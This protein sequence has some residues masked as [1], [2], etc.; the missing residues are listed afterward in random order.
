MGK[1]RDWGVPASEKRGGICMEIKEFAVKVERAVRKK[2]GADYETECRE[3]AKN[4]GVLLHGLVIRRAE[5]AIAPTIYLNS[6]WEA[7]E[8]GMT[9]SEVVSRILT[10]YEEDVVKQGIDV[11]FFRD[12]EK[13]KER[14]CFRLVNRE[15][16]R[17]QLAE[18]PYLPILDLAV[19]FYYAFD[20]N[21][22]SNGSI[23]VNRSHMELWKTTERELFALAVKNMPK[24][25]PMEMGIL[26]SMLLDLIKGDPIYILTNVRH[27][28]GACT[29]LYPGA[30]E[31]MGEQ[32][33]D[34]Y[35]LIPCSVHEFLLLPV[36]DERSTEELKAMIHE[37]NSCELAP[38]DVLSDALYYYDVGERRMS[39][40][41]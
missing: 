20:G 40:V 8:E 12:F 39:I 27:N 41:E 13:V 19:C 11:A 21:G 30:L 26:G 9:L 17:E 18:I 7:Y 28:F 25:Y 35:Y 23:T 6:F 36:G 38:E 2:L 31:R 24:L 15:R 1:C 10:I 37:V 4:N 3:V 16:N 34:S 14:I 22:I 5:D 33:G 29:I 32:I